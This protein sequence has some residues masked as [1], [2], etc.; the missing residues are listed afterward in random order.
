LV[1]LRVSEVM[2]G[3]GIVEVVMVDVRNSFPYVNRLAVVEGR[4]LF[5]RS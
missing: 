4:N 1:G 3:A 2:A 5:A